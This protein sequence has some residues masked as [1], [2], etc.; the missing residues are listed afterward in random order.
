MC[1][2]LSLEFHFNILAT[3]NNKKQ[4]KKPLF[5]EVNL[6]GQNLSVTCRSALLPV[7]GASGHAK[8][9]PWAAGNHQ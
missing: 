8:A 9:V 5:A 4:D 6:T 7:H 1:V 3:M 2:P